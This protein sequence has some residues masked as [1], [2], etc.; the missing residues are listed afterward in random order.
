MYPRQFFGLPTQVGMP[1]T[2]RQLERLSVPA[3]TARLVHSRH[4]LLALRVCRMMDL[5]TEQARQPRYNH[6]C[7]AFHGAKPCDPDYV[8]PAPLE[9]QLDPVS[10]SRATLIMGML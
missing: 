10:H 4:H 2:M 5:P 6:R 9:A 7:R 1:L 3:L 8:P